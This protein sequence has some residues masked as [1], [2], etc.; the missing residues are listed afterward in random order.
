MTDKNL[1][2][3]CMV[4]AAGVLP[5]AIGNQIRFVPVEWSALGGGTVLLRHGHEELLGRQ[6]W[7]RKVRVRASFI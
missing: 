4:H 2:V 6:Q 7:V 1:L 5:D 3:R